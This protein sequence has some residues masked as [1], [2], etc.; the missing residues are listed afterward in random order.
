MRAKVTKSRKWLRGQVV[1]LSAWLWVL[2]IS[3]DSAWGSPWIETQGIERFWEIQQ[4]LTRDEEPGEERWRKLFASPGYRQLEE[5]EKRSRW[6][7]PIFAMAFRP[8]LKKTLAARKTSGDFVGSMLLPHLEMAADRPER[9]RSFVREFCRDET[10]EIALAASKRYLPSGGI[11]RDL[12]PQV[13][14]VIVDG[15]GKALPQGIV[16]DAFALSFWEHPVMVLAHELHHVFRKPLAQVER[17][18]LAE[19]E[20]KLFTVIEQLEEEGV[21]EMI[22]K[23]GWLSS[24]IPELSEHPLLRWV[25]ERYRTVENDA[26]ESVRELDR[27]LF[28]VGD[29]PSV[30]E[31]EGEKL[32]E[33]ISP[34]ERHTVGLY[35]AFAIEER[36]GRERL[37]ETVGNP[38][39]FV[40]AYSEAAGLSSPRPSLSAESIACLDDWEKRCIKESSRGSKGR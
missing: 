34:P 14:L 13:F 18:N 24:G 29:D 9:V 23:P 28:A 22:D 19:E 37:V 25:Q 8:S 2:Q 21:A 5:V 16:L 26:P 11:R 3:V 40:R 36:L 7:K 31:T 39:S 20:K 15:D 32:F 6:M 12:V 30:V 33:S 10:L 1:L 27:A 17:K 4:I 35:M 38:F